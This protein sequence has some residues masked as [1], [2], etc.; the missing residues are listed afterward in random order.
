MLKNHFMH[1]HILVPANIGTMH[2][3]TFPAICLRL[4]VILPLWQKIKDRAKYIHNAHAHE[5]AVPLHRMT[6]EPACILCTSW[7]V[8]KTRDYYDI[9]VTL[10]HPIFGKENFYMY[11]SY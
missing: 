2:V 3:I 4:P 6:F 9:H 1:G 5:S 7:S 11:T 8:A 10:Q